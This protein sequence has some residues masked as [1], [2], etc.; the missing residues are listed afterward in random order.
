MEGNFG[1]TDGKTADL[2]VPP[3][4]IVIPQGSGNEQDVGTSRNGNVNP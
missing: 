1:S 3:L 4:K 2:K